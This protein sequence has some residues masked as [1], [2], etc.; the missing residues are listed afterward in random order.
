MKGKEKKHGEEGGVGYLP[1]LLFR[2]TSCHAVSIEDTM[3]L[4]CVW[5][6]VWCMGH[7]TATAQR[8]WQWQQTAGVYTMIR[9]II[10]YAHLLILNLN[11]IVMII[12]IIMILKCLRDHESSEGVHG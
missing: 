6:E 3:A 9:S 10:M 7:D 5:G 12:R 4:V 2:L 8:Q 1:S 11:M